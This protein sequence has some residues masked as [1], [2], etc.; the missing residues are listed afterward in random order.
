MKNIKEQIPTKTLSLLKKIGQLAEQRGELAFAV[1]GFVRDLLLK[2]NSVDIDITI[3]GDGITFAEKL[4]HSSGS[5]VEAFT[6]FGT[7][8]VVVPGFGK[9]DV[10]TARRESYE[11][12]GALPKVE[13]SGIVQDLYRRDFTLNA[14]AMSLSSGSFLQLLDPF[15]GLEDLKKGRIRALHTKSFEDDPT[16]IFRAIRFEQRF[17]KRIEKQTQRW[18][19]KSVKGEFIQKVSGERLRN[20]LRLIF[21]EPHPEGAVKRLKELGALRHIHPALDVLPATSAFLSRIPSA[22]EYFHKLKI[23]LDEETMVW[24]Q[25]LLAKPNEAEAQALS[26]R[27]M[28]SRSEQK[29]VHQS[30]EAYPAL[31]HKMANTPLAMSQFYKMLCPLRP[32]V[33]CFLLAAS[34]GV[35]HKK[36]LEYFKKIQTSKPWVRGKD[37]QALGIEPGF[38]YSFILLEA[39]NGQLDGKFKSRGQTLKWVK[40]TFAK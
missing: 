36:L 26:K 15:G 7:S 17:Q 33:Q 8:I 5:E 16:R 14:M 2:K 30:A 29:I 40:E 9:V 38:R 22:I 32:E 10:A 6:Q 25:A 13:K 37:L 35:L 20:E 24:F 34:T 3:E 1:G 12:P 39:L 19:M 11:H 27:L 31:L 18:L 21:R 28:L 23:G 4:A